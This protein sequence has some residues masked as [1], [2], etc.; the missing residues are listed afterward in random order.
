MGVAS[1]PHGCAH[2]DTHG[3]V[4]VASM[5][6]P[7]RTHRGMAF[8]K[9]QL[10]RRRRVASSYLPGA[11]MFSKRRRN[12]TTRNTSR[13]TLFD[14]VVDVIA[15]PSGGYGCGCLF[16]LAAD[17]PARKKSLQISAAESS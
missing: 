1:A 6:V 12:S 15:R 8:C 9:Q 3:D 16:G 13:R 17:R 10:M 11:S 7:V 14:G 2:T 5:H 4:Y